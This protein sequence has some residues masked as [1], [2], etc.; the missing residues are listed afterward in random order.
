MS[1]RIDMS[2]DT[3][4]EDMDGR[5][6][7]VTTNG[8]VA[9]DWSYSGE[10]LYLLR[11]WE[12]GI[13]L[14]DDDIEM[15]RILL[16]DVAPVYEYRE[17][18]PCVYVWWVYLMDCKVWT[19]ELSTDP[20]IS[21]ELEAGSFVMHRRAAAVCDGAEQFRALHRELKEARDHAE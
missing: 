1:D 15:W 12:D 2:A 8:A 19:V 3:R 16:T 7:L 14:D 4:I 11:G 18:G 10:S 13:V 5:R 20:D 17:G 9:Y 6:C 21:Q